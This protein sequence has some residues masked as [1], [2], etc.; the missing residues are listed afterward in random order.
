MKNIRL[1]VLVPLLFVMS[2]CQQQQ[3]QPQQKSL[4]AQKTVKV[5][6]SGNYSGTASAD[7]CGLYSFKV[8]VNNQNVDG[9]ANGEKDVRCELT[10][11]GKL[12]DNG[13]ISGDT[14]GTD[15][16][17][18]NSAKFEW[19]YNGTFSGTLNKDGGPIEVILNANGHSCPANIPC[20]DVS[21]KLNAELKRM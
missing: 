12:D 2:G 3:P 14:S 18:N 15:R 9:T 19:Y 16:L 4:P 5:D 7:T 20:V 11:S 17:I 1:L 13:K 8:N 10:L 6:L 21:K